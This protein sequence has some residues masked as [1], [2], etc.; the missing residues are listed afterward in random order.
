M[1]SI[2]LYNTLIKIPGV[3]AAEAQ[4]VADDVVSKNEVATKADIKD[5]AT[6]ADLERMAT[7]ADIKDMATKADIKDMATKADLEKL[8]TKVER[9]VRVATM[10]TCSFMVGYSLVLVA[11]AQLFISK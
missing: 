10:W 11:L 1:A 9:T 3:D 2:R 5:M 6:K 8:E 7:K 4:G